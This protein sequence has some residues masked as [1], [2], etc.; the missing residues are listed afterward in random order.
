MKFTWTKKLVGTSIALGVLAVGTTV[1]WAASTTS[2]SSTS[3]TPAAQSNPSAWG[4]GG[5]HGRGGPG[6]P[7][8]FGGGSP[9]ALAAQVLGISPQ[10]LMTDLQSGQSIAQVAQS[11]GITESDL[12]AKMKAALAQNLQK[13]VTQQESNFAN[14]ATKMVEQKGLPQPPHG[15]PG[16]GRFGGMHGFGV[17]GQA[18]TVLNL[19]P[20][21]L[22]S[23]LA[24]GKSLVDIASAQGMSEQTFMSKLEAAVQGDL[25][26]A[27]SAGRLTQAQAD[28]QYSN[29]TSQVKT[30]VEQK[31]LPTPKAWGG[32]G[33]EGPGF[34]GPGSAAGQG[35]GSSAAAGS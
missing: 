3:T 21:T 2:N 14:N 30:M 24:S 23:D 10:T 4:H 31:G 34:A 26:K 1:T 32:M 7:G 20:Q 22:H 5:W 33:P 17:M 28:T 11:K 15:G 35:S 6:G 8:G 18:A 13:M 19:S 25:N 27:V 29:F 12:I 16:P 9:V